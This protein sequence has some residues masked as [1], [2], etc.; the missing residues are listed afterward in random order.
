MADVVSTRPLI[1]KLG[2]QP[3]ARVALIDVDD[4]E[5]RALLAERTQDISEGEPLPGS[6]LVF[7]AIDAGAGLGQLALL[8]DRIVPNGA[9]W[10]VFRKGKSATVRD[11]E[12]MEAAR[13]FGLIDNK[14]VAFS[15]THTALRLVIPIAL[16]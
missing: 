4:A 10:V 16:R 3:A 5:F 14:V 12:V 9:I 7:V 6:D 1:D 15:P 11:I 8:R 2:V 13:A